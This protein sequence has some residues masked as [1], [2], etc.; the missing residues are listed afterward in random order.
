MSTKRYCLALDLKDN[1]ELIAAYEYYHKSDAIWPEILA[2]N[3]E[4]GIVSMD[5]YRAGN[6]LFMIMETVP[7]FDLQRDFA[8]L[9][10][11]PKQQEWAALMLTF[12]QRLP[13]AADDTLWVEMQCIFS[14]N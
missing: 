5:I 2:G 8:R 10:T 13:F 4:V 1:P 6:R 11:L 14:Q 9:G 7:T 3:K 12:Q